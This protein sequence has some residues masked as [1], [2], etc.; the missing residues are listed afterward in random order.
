MA[1][2]L[3]TGCL[4]AGGT[5]AARRSATAVSAG[6]A[7]RPRRRDAH[8]DALDRRRRRPRAS[9]ASEVVGEEPHL[10]RPRRVVDLDE[11]RA[12][13]E[14]HRADVGGDRRR[15]PPRPSARTRRRP[16][17]ARR[18][19]AATA[20]RRRA[21]RVSGTGSSPVTVTARSPRL[22]TSSTTVPALDA[23]RRARARPP[24]A[25]RPAVVIT[26]WP[27]G[28]WREQRRRPAGV[29]LGQ[30]VVE[31]QHRRRAGPLGD[32][33]VGAE[34]QRQ[35]QRALL[36]L[37]RV[38]ARRQ[39]VDRQRQL[40]AVRAD[41]RHAAAHVGVAGLRPARR[42][43]R[44]AATAGRTP[45]PTGVGAP[46]SCV[47][48]LDD[49]RRRSRSTSVARACP[50]RSPTS[51]SLASHTSSVV[52]VVVVERPPAWRS[53]VLRWRTMR[54]S[55][56]RAASYFTASATSVSSRKR[57][58][59]PGPPL[60]SVRSS[61]ENT[62]TRTTPSR[63]RA[64]ASR[65]RLTCT[66]LRPARH[67]LGLD[68][69]RRDRRRRAPRPG[70]PPRRRRRAPAR[71]SARRGSWP[72]WPGRRAPRR[73][74]SCPARCRRRRPSCPAVELE[75]RRRVVAEVDELEALDDHDRPGRIRL[76]A[77]G[78]ASAGTGS[79]RGR[80]PRMTAGFI[81][82]SVDSVTSSPSTASTPA[83]R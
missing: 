50:K 42:P 82:S 71:R 1:S 74:S 18:R 34:P 83:A 16:R 21:R 7:A 56:R 10:G 65:W 40:V 66:R 48:G 19:R 12:V 47:V 36:A 20:A 44:C 62:V 43:A 8:L 13:L 31:H 53:S 23:Q 5:T 64:R 33:A 49:E 81:G 2:S 4:S 58:R 52:A 14:A 60:T 6:S 26:T 78:P 72:A 27:G 61:G 22:A 67:E 69:R 46:A 28:R 3:P 77:P 37:R 51:A 63:S 9:R 25:A 75:R 80:R 30:H 32:Q 17:P 54:S 39:A 76:T 35:R 45:A 41:G 70:R 11:Q 24:P 59:S 55:S 57:R 73:G 29:E 79:R 68:Q 15:R 38:G